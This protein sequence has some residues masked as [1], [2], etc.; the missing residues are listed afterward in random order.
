V[1]AQPIV[2]ESNGPLSL[3]PVCACCGRPA[4]HACV[5]K[6]NDPSKAKEEL[7]LDAVGLVVLPVHL[8]RSIQ[9]LKTK[10]ARIPMCLKCRFNYFLPGK[11]SMIMIVLVTLCF[12]DAFHNGFQERYGLMFCDLLGAVIF[13]ILAVKKSVRHSLQAMPV[14][15]Y[16]HKGK[17]R[18][19]VYGGPI[20]D[21]FKGIE[22]N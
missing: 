13:M 8:M 5:I 16:L 15:V 21:S 7:M 6:P 10:N 12:I 19:V 14:N 22:N 3:P 11:I 2:I 20:Y 18:Y 17:Y 4:H 1:K 9:I